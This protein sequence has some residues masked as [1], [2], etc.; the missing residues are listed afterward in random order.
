MREVC[1]IADLVGPRFT[2]YSVIGA[3]LAAW[4]DHHEDRYLVLCPTCHTLVAYDEELALYT[5]MVWSAHRCC[6]GCRTRDSFAD[7][8]GLVGAV[9]EVWRMTGEYPQSGSWVEAIPW[10]QFLVRGKQIEAALQAAKAPAMAD[11]RPFERQG[12]S[13]VGDDQTVLSPATTK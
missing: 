5:E 1:T 2:P 9:L 13:R 4:H 8:P 6:Q 7:N 12:V 11:A 3:S 10:C